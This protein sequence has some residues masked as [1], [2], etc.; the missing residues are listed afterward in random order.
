MG[1][2]IKNTIAGIGLNINQVRFLSD[3]PNPVSLKMITGIEYDLDLS[4]DQLLSDL[5]KRYK[6]LITG[7]FTEIRNEYIPT[8]PVK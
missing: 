4:L 2:E 7:D 3:A 6:Q 8:F 5:D 1:N